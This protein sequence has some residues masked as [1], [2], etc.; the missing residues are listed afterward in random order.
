M[1]SA[2]KSVYYFSF[3]LYLIGLTLILVPNL[4]LKTLQ[5]PQSNEVWIRVVGVLVFCIGYYYHCT[6]AENIKALLKHTIPTRIFVCIAFTAFA[7]LDYV[8][9]VLVVFGV[10]DFLGALWTWITLRTEKA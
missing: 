4:F 2:A 6:G 3:Y 7:A 9:P 5:L 1:S 10:I 8:S